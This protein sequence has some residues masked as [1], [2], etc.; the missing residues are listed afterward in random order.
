MSNFDKLRLIALIGIL[1]THG[2]IQNIT[3]FFTYIYI[4][5]FIIY[6]Y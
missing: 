3:Y 5:L 2:Y 6:L 4:Y 1:N